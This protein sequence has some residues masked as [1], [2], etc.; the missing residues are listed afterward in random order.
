VNDALDAFMMHLEAGNAAAVD[1]TDDC[2]DIAR[3]GGSL[4]SEEQ[5]NLKKLGNVNTI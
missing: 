1:A 2:D 4:S 5:N 3:D